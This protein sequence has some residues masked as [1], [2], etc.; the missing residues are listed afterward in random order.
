MICYNLTIYSYCFIVSDF[1]HP[2]IIPTF[3]CVTLHS[4]KF[5]TK[6]SVHIYDCLIMLFHR[7]LHLLN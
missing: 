6:P 1:G 7:L 4:R 2:K 5:P 3:V